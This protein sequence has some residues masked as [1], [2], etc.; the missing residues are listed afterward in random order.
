MAL[1]PDP[2]PPAARPEPEQTAAPLPPEIRQVLDRIDSRLR[3]VEMRLIGMEQNVGDLRVQVGEVQDQVSR[4]PTAWQL[5]ISVGIII[6]V[7]MGL[8]F[9]VILAAGRALGKG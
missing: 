7:S 4:V 1:F 5:L 8:V 2:L 9:V 6:G 3:A